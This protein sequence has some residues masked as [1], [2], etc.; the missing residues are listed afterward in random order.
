MILCGGNAVFCCSGVPTLRVKSSC[1]VQTLP[2]WAIKS[3]VPQPAA[4]SPVR[5]RV[6]IV[7]TEYQISP[8]ETAWS[9]AET[10]LVDRDAA[11]AL[12]DRLSL[13]YVGRSRRLADRRRDRARSFDGPRKAASDR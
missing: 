3:A 12:P 10:T 13:L 5:Y 9:R 1:A 8:R 2:A 11:N 7:R 4:R 6:R